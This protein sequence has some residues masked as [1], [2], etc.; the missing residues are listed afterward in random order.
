MKLPEDEKVGWRHIKIQQ[1]GKNASGQ[2][3]YLSLSGLELYGTVNGVCDELGK[4]AKEAEANLR[5]QRRLMRTHILKHMV[6]GARVVR[7]ID[8]KWRDQDGRTPGEGT[9]TGELHNGWIDVTWDHGGSNSYRMGAEGKFDLKLAPG[10]EPGAATTS[11]TAATAASSTA[12]AISTSSIKVSSPTTT[13]PQAV[14]SPSSPCQ[15]TSP[16]RQQSAETAT[17]ASAGG[18]K[19]SPRVFPPAGR[20]ANSTPSLCESAAPAE[21]AAADD[22]AAH[23]GGPEAKRPLAESFEQTVSADNLAAKQAAEQ[24]ANIVLSE[25]QEASANLKADGG[26]EQLFKRYVVKAEETKEEAA[27][28]SEAASTAESVA[29]SVLSE[30]IQSA[31]AATASGGAF[32][33]PPTTSSVGAFSAP[34]SVRVPISSS[35]QSLFSDNEVD[36]LPPLLEVVDNIVQEDD[37]EDDEDDEDEMEDAFMDPIDI[38]ATSSGSE[39]SSGKIPH[40]VIHQQQPPPPA[41]PAPL[42]GLDNE[43]SLADLEQRLDR[44]VSE[45]LDRALSNFGAIARSSSVDNSLPP[46]SQP[47]QQQ[48]RSS[49]DVVQLAS[50]LASDLADLV[51]SMNLGGGNSSSES[52][53]KRKSSNANEPPPPAPVLPMQSPTAAMIG[54]ATPPPVRRQLSD[55]SG[56]AAAN[57][58]PIQKPPPPSTAVP[59]SSTES[60]FLPSK[61]LDFSSLGSSSSGGELSLSSFNQALASVASGVGASDPQPQPPPVT[62]VSSSSEPNLTASEASAVSLLETF[63]AVARRRS[64]AQT[65]TTPSSSQVKQ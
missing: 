28:A 20:K 45:G 25:K 4:A 21:S 36:L 13:G 38:A 44:A 63:A 65:S 57:P 30:A 32:S 12:A 43:A 52:S 5:R 56:A 23:A 58:T 10:S 22:G 15:Y 19:A 7:G 42:G 26:E 14:D 62:E 64:G 60:T 6:I 11:T 29:S 24:A 3:H 9:V 1:N 54:K 37:D 31:A 18:V 8:W 27:V 2:T 55:G 51:H 34:P 17:V 59:T 40:G 39:T 33:P 35:A 16:T 47:Q 50:S 49:E 46:V 53:S 48:Q 61:L 41:P